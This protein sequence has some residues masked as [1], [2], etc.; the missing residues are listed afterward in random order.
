MR[1]ETKS[2]CISGNR[3]WVMGL[4]LFIG[5]I[6]GI[7]IAK[8]Y[9]LS[10]MQADEEAD[11]RHAKLQKEL[12]DTNDPIQLFAKV[13]EVVKP[14]VVNI[15]TLKN[16]NLVYEDFPFFSSPRQQQQI[17]SGV[18]VDADG[19]ILTN[20]HV[21]GGADE[22]KVILA[23][24]REFKGK[25]I[26]GDEM[27]DLAVVRIKAKNLIP[28]A[29][30]DSDSTKI[31][32]WVVAIGNPF[33]LDNT[34]TSGIISARREAFNVSGKGNDFIQT[35]A[36]I[37]PGNSGG[38]LVNLKGEVIGINSS[39]LTRSGGYQ[40]IGF[41]IPSNQAKIIMARLIESG[42]IQRPYLGVYLSEINESLARHYGLSGLQVLLKELKIK[43]PVGAFIMGIEKKSPSE[44]AGLLE[45]DVVVIYNK[46][47]I[48]NPGELVALIGKSKIGDTVEV[49][50]V[51][52]GKEQSFK[53]TVGER[54]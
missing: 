8:Y 38:P 11:K 39:I 5:I 7:I 24:K 46:E 31:G 33:G 13:A 44:K 17:G 2:R 51:R 10:V 47:K 1:S 12:R 43:E 42:K 48:T 19:Y 52:D 18:I 35:D 50:V 53:V 34:V 54:E 21:V 14:S 41:A 3:K 36:A 28:A 29:M 23:D 20:Y 32:E 49:T 27:T 22:I 30:G 25:V 6:A 37:N 15:S 4:T 9:E 40:G 16:I 26:G 45:G